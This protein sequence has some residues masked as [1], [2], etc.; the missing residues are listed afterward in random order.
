MSGRERRG[1][2]AR[3]SSLA[4]PR[5]WGHRRIRFRGGDPALPRRATAARVGARRGGARTSPAASAQLRVRVAASAAAGAGRPALACPG[6]A[7][8]AAHMAD[9]VAEVADSSAAALAWPAGSL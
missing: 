5:P 3:L 6:V 9:S 1:G 8:S 2:S 7:D 4:K